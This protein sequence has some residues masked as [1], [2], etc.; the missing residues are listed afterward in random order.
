MCLYC[1]HIAPSGPPLSIQLTAESFNSV[2]ISWEPPLAEQQ[3]GRIVRYHVTVTD[4]ALTANRDLTYDI[5]DGRV[6]LIDM[7]DADSSYAIR[8]A[9]ATSVGIGPFSA[10][11]TVTTLRNGKS[12]IIISTYLMFT[13]AL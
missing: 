5:S 9:A 6:Q 4:A 10:I 3:N 7:L 8:M 2:T 1:I 12:I 13:I 11:R